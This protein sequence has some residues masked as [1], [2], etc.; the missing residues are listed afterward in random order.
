[1]VRD[2]FCTGS[3]YNYAQFHCSDF[4][5]WLANL[6]ICLKIF[7]GGVRSCSRPAVRLL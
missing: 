1:M 4:D 3:E 2:V 5:L 6:N 7:L